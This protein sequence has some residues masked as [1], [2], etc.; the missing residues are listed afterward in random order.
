MQ[1]REFLLVSVLLF[2]ETIFGTISLTSPTITPV[3]SGGPSHGI[4]SNGKNLLYSNGNA[5]STGNNKDN[6]KLSNAKLTFTASTAP[7]ITAESLDL[8]WIKIPFL[9]R[10]KER[11]PDSVLKASEPIKNIYT[12][13]LN[14]LLFKVHAWANS[15]DDDLDSVAEYLGYD[16]ETIDLINISITELLS[17]KRAC[18]VQIDN[19]LSLFY[20]SC[21][22]K[23][24]ADHTL[25]DVDKVKQNLRTLANRF[26][27]STE[28]I[29]RL[30]KG[31]LINDLKS[32]LRLIENKA[33]T[34]FGV[35]IH[36]MKMKIFT[37]Q[38]DDPTMTKLKDRH[39]TLFNTKKIPEFVRTYTT[40][41]DEDKVRNYHD[42]ILDVLISDIFGFAYNHFELLSLLRTYELNDTDKEIIKKFTTFANDFTFLFIDR[43]FEFKGIISSE[44]RDAMYSLIQF[45][46]PENLPSD[47]NSNLS[48]EDKAALRTSNFG[49]SVQFE[50]SI[51]DYFDDQKRSDVELNRYMN[52]LKLNVTNVIIG[53]FTMENEYEWNQLRV[54]KIDQMDFNLSMVEDKKQYLLD[55]INSN[56]KNAMDIIDVFSKEFV[57]GKELYDKYELNNNVTPQNQPQG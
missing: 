17:E 14:L 38:T 52:K 36:S 54:S 35:T 53:S 4:S 23:A 16:K 26:S 43:S 51:S 56:T 25:A 30:D 39:I 21:D 41:T 49:K 32:N 46:N 29:Q 34:P 9:N 47:F 28:D 55:Q 11:V 6:F 7:K 18:H 24:I 45:L 1:V 48:D 3:I 33:E 10:N 37:E 13:T 15:N 12:N 22:L 57:L 27:M 40:E 20:Y 44:V 42:T 19:L 31:N 8:S 5:Y 2:H 50:R